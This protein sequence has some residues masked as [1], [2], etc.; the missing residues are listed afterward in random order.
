MK[1]LIAGAS[2]FV[3]RALVPLLQARGHEVISLV[4]NRA[5]GPGE[6]AWNPADGLPPGAYQGIRAVI[7]LCGENIASNRWTKARKKRLVHS[8][9]EPVEAL[10][11]G[12]RQSGAAV[13]VFL[14]ASALGYYGNTGDFSVTEESRPGEGF[15][16]RLCIEWEAATHGAE[17]LGLRLVRLRMGMVLGPGGAL[18]KMAPIFRAGLGGHLGSGRQWMSWISR[19]DAV[20]AILWCLENESVRG[21]VN[22]CSPNPVM[23]TEFTR[24]LAQAVR[25]PARLAVPGIVLSVAYGQLAKEALLTSCRAKPAVL[26][27]SG[28]GY[29]HP[30]LQAALDEALAQK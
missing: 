22:L 12:L 7:N 2:G 10:V 16:A 17:D 30:Q 3:G 27:S 29:A 19:Q 23:N 5:A 28:F 13:K 21:P 11:A 24:G 9:I 20:R 8:R 14:S 1:I 6:I 25:R 26:A 18:E 15:L 4:R